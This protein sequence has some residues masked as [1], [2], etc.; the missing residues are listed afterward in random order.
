MNKLAYHLWSMSRDENLL[1]TA[2]IV[3]IALAG[4]SYLSAG[5]QTVPSP[6]GDSYQSL[7]LTSDSRLLPP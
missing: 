7:R 6:R 2:L 5:L 3:C 1:R 4:I